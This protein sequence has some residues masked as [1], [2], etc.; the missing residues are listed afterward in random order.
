MSPRLRI[1]AGPRDSASERDNGGAV[2]S[3]SFRRHFGSTAAQLK[4]HTQVWIVIDVH[5]KMQFGEL[6][7]AWPA[8]RLVAI[9]NSLTG[10]VSVKTFQNRKTTVKRIW[11]RISG[12]N[13]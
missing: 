12:H 9:W 11:E 4:T 6:A 5:Q 8:E 1:R 2:R 3:V 13:R 10:V 7:A